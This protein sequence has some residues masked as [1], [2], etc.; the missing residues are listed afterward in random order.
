MADMVGA[1]TQGALVTSAENVEYQRRVH[2]N[3]GVVAGRRRLEFVGE[4]LSFVAGL[5]LLLD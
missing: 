4:G 1:A 5:G 2:Q 3:R